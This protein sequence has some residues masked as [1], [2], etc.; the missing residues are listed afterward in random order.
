MPPTNLVHVSLAHLDP[1][2]LTS[3]DGKRVDVSLEA[4]AHLIENPPPMVLAHLGA[5]PACNS[6]DG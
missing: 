1:M 2:M 5:R 3:P 4:V 6:D